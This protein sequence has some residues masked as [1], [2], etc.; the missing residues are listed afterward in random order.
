VVVQGCAGLGAFTGGLRGSPNVVFESQDPSGNLD[1]L[2]GTAF[3]QPLDASPHSVW[4]ASFYVTDSEPAFIKVVAYPGDPWGLAWA[5]TSPPRR[6]DFEVL[7]YGGI[8]GDPPPDSSGCAVAAIADPVAVPVI[9]GLRCWPVP[10]AGEVS[11]SWVNERAERARIDV[12][13]AAGRLARH[14]HDG[15]LR[16]RDVVRWDARQEDG[17]RA[18]AGVYFVR[19]VTP[20]G[21]AV[22]RVVLLQR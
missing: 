11:L 12:Y 18:P 13:D 20:A 19:M 6:L 21:T 7:A 3:I 15:L 17:G 16:P 2:G 1:L 22:S 8:N 9:P 5:Q 14:L 10:A 4:G